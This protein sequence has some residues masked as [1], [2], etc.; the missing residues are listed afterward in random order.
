MGTTSAIGSSP[1]VLS[2]TLLVERCARGDEV[3]WQALYQQ[4]RAGATRFLLRLGVKGDAVEDACQEVFLQAFRFLPKFRGECSFRTWLYRICASEARRARRRSQL[5]AFVSSLLGTQV[6]EAT[7]GEMGDERAVRLVQEAL[8][9]LPEP[10][11]LAFVLYELEGMSGREA[12]EVAGCPEAT[13]FRRLHYA[14]KQF[15]HYIV[16]QGVTA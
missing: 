4:H 5:K 2:S 15:Q 16:E 12:A 3:A 11:R 8:D 13:M 14:R 6:S 1:P 9:C 10:E 7:T